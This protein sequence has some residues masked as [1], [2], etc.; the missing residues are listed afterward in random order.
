MSI[1]TLVLLL[2]LVAALPAAAIWTSTGAP[3]FP[4]GLVAK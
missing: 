1:K 3:A 4:S 2:A